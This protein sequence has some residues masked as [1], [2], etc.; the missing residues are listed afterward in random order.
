MSVPVPGLVAA[1][2]GGGN[3]LVSLGCGEIL[4]DV[5][6]SHQGANPRLSY[7]PFL[8]ARQKTLLSSLDSVPLSRA[9]NRLGQTLRRLFKCLT[10]DVQEAYASVGLFPLSLLLIKM[11]ETKTN[12]NAKIIIPHWLMAGTFE[13]GGIN[14]PILLPYSSVNQTFPSGPAAMP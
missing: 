11:N 10:R 5:A 8:N 3:Q 1:V 14:F 6:G 4:S 2:L 12:T 9:K 13:I 7:G